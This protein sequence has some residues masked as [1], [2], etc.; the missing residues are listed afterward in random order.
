MN[1]QDA[2]AG[3]RFSPRLGP[4]SL[5]ME[6]STSALGELSDTPWMAPAKGDIL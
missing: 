6:H 1:L 5:L 3:C 4:L 2:E